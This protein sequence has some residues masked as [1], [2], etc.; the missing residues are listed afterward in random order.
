MKLA[1]SLF[2]L[3]APLVVVFLVASILPGAAYGRTRANAESVITISGMSVFGGLSKDVVSRVVHR[4]V[5]SLE[6]Y[7]RGDGSTG[8]LVMSL[9]VRPDGTIKSVKL[10]RGAADWRTSMVDEIGTWR[11]SEADNGREARVIVVLFVNA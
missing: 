3:T 1:H 5:H 4:R 7:Y 8:Q 10:L 9:T 6:S 2:S 11:F